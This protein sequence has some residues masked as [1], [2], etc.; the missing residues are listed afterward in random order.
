M[1]RTV[2]GDSGISPR[3]QVYAE[4]QMLKHAGPVMVLDKFG[5]AK[6]MPKNKG[7][8][9]KFRRPNVFTAATV[10]LQEGV[11]PTPDSITPQDVTVVMQ[12]YSCSWKLRN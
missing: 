5:M 2:Y 4:R 10:P 6:P 8:V 9:I 12:Q 11:T 3:T 7:E 1:T